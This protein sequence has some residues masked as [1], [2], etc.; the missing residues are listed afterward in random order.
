MPSL[1]RNSPVPYYQQVYEQ[2]SEGIESGVY[3]AGKRLPS[4]REC[5][6]ELGVS[7]TTIELAYQRLVEEGYIEAK[8]GSGFTICEIG[9]GPDKAFAEYSEE[10]R[11]EREKLEAHS[12]ELSRQAKPTFDFAYDSVDASTFPFNAWARKCRDVFF[13][14]GAQA[15]C[16]HN[17]RQGL[18]DL[19]EQ[20]SHYLQSEYGVT[21]TPEQVLVMPTT[22]DLVTEITML[23]DPED[24]VVAM[25]EPGYDEVG[26]RMRERGC[27]VRLVPVCPYPA[28]EEAEKLLQGV[29]LLFATPAC[30]FPTNHVMPIDMRKSLV[31]WASEH[32]AYVIDDE[33]GWEFQ[34]GVARMPSLAAL[35]DAGHV[36]TI[37]TFSNSFTPAVSLSYATLPPKLMLKWRETR[38][39]AHT[40]VPWQTQAAMAQFMS[41]GHWR[42]HI[43]KLRTS[44][45]NKRER[46]LKAIRGHMGDAVD[47]VMLAYP[48]RESMQA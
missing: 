14:E 8:R 4:I 39:D 21:C 44:V 23:F 15:A 3:P 13:S 22:K 9:I 7:N 34:S 6:R 40:Q 33:Y 36:I 16:L 17:D 45:L 2:I 1:D 43:R 37:G 41:E 42:T 29:S 35:D 24:T 47:E 46:V 12:R 30:Q 38:R 18:A 27:D 20:I 32:G 28:E 48:P 19:R 31:T 26:K 25:E 5:A 10:Y 11:Q